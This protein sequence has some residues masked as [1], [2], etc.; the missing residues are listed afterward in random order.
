MRG[1]SILTNRRRAIVA[2]AHSVVFLLIAVRQVLA[3]SPATGV[4]KTAA[5]PTGTWILCA[6]FAI[7]SIILVWLLAVSRGL[8]ERFYFAFCTSSALS[9]LLRTA[10]GD[11]AFHAGIYVRVVM[12]VSA[13]VVGCMIVRRH[14]PRSGEQ[15]AQPS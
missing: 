12:L 15:V 3:S 9:G 11:R 8:M 14:S 4:W 5:V 2:L 7:V 10:A 13:V 6:I 1:F